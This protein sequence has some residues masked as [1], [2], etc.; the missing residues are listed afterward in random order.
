MPKILLAEALDADAE[1]RL[2]A[3]ATVVRTPAGDAETLRRLIVDCDALVART[4][5]R[6]TRAVLEAGRRLRVV[7]VAGVGVDSVD[8][9]AARELG[10]AVLNTPAAA[11]HAVA[12]LALALMLQL[13]RPIP[14][15]ADEY[16]AGR[17][18]AA[19]AEP[20]G[21]ELCE[22]TVGIVGMGRIGSQVARRCAA[23]FGARV[24]FND[25][26][27][28]G[29]F[30]FPAAPVDKA[31]IWS[32]SDIVSLHVPL[33]EDTRGLISSAVVARFRPTALLIN[34]ARGAVVDT[35]ALTA[36]LEDGRIAGAGLDVT[37]PEP[38]SPDHPLFACRRCV[39][40]PHIASRTEGGM[41]RM[42]AV[43][44]DVLAFLGREEA[45][46]AS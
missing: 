37:E 2:E 32:E 11:T 1:R 29:P 36:A 4:H 8:L 5:T 31:T 35:S 9:A 12:D 40:T 42:C 34:T 30:D 44:E 14:H 39:L 3:G 16:R 43:V 25:V 27:E 20:H 13:L 15:L 23:G 24:L 7:G 22:L 41:R 10:I 28:V 17:F 6:V 38:L 18:R 19:R 21:V 46:R 33:T 26:V 45:H